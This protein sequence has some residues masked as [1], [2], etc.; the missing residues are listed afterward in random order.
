MH[1]RRREEIDRIEFI[2]ERKKERKE[3]KKKKIE[4]N[5]DDAVNE[6]RAIKRSAISK[7]IGGYGS[8]KS[9]LECEEWRGSNRIE[10]YIVNGYMRRRRNTV[11][12]RTVIVT[13]LRERFRSTRRRRLRGERSGALVSFLL[14]PLSAIPRAGRFFGIG[15][16]LPSRR[17]SS[18]RGDEN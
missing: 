12:P 15:V 4:R 18:P 2:R 5:A 11:G 14:P 10:S 6:G 1:I 8:G 17:K 9:F 13:R 16:R 3:K 7:E